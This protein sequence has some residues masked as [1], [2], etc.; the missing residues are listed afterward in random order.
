MFNWPRRVRATLASQP[1]D[2]RRPVQRVPE[3]QAQSERPQSAPGAPSSGAI[4]DDLVEAIIEAAD[5]SIGIQIR[6]DWICGA[7][8]SSALQ[9]CYGGARIV[10]WRG[11][12]IPVA[13]E[14]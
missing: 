7:R 5:P 12:E 6:L 10:A 14:A 1:S 2:R 11:V 3:V 4:P 9:G 13:P 8:V